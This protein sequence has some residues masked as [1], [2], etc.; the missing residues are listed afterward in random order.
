MILNHELRRKSVKAV[1]AYFNLLSQS[2]PEQN[3]QINSFIEQRSF[4]KLIV[5][6]IVKKFSAFY[7]A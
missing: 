5:A 7:E 2:L 4:E 3:E 1:V 6:Q